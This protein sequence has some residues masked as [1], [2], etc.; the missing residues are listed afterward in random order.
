MNEL[1]RKKKYFELLKNLDIE[2]VESD[3]QVIDDRVVFKVKI[4]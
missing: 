4:A 3:Y 2:K 1:S